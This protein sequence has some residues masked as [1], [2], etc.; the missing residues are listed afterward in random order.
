M[1]ARCETRALGAMHSMPGLVILM[2]RSRPRRVSPQAD[3]P[4]SAA[5][6]HEVHSNFVPSCLC[7]AISACGLTHRNGL[8]RG[9]TCI[10]ARTNPPH[11]SAAS[12]SEGAA[13][14]RVPQHPAGLLH[15]ARQA[16]GIEQRRGGQARRAALARICARASRIGRRGNGAGDVGVGV[17][18]DPVVQAR[19]VQD[20][21]RRTARPSAGPPGSPPERPATAPRSS[22]CRRCAGTG[23]ARCRSAPYASQVRGCGA[24]AIRSSR[25]RATPCAAKRPANSSRNAA[26]PKLR[27]FSTRRAVGQRVQDAR[28]GGNHASFSRSGRPK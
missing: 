27:L 19:G 18:G 15:R 3:S 23:R 10:R 1:S 28:P 9:E 14:P 13:T 24:V 21:S 12:S 2:L 17:A 16:R 7:G 5:D 6:R 11:H 8:S 25:S 4:Q 22:W 26:S 20:R